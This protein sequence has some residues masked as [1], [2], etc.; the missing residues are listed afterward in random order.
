MLLND[1]LDVGI[2]KQ[3]SRLN[4]FEIKINRQHKDH[5]GEEVKLINNQK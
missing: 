4:K 2:L 1:V 3:K 5:N